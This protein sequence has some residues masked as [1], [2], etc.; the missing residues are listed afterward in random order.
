MR[1]INRDVV[2]HQYSNDWV[3]IDRE[4]V[5]DGESGFKSKIINPLF[6]TE[7]TQSDVDA[8][9]EHQNVGFFWNY[10]HYDANQEKFVRKVDRVVMSHEAK[11]R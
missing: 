5:F 1:Y 8:M 11:P 2:V 10:F 6:L 4:P 7:V 3:M 9:R